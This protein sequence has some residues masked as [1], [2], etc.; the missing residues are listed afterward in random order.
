MTTR[1]LAVLA[2]ASA[3]LLAGSSP[4]A[5]YDTQTFAA[6]GIA[7]QKRERAI[8]QH[9]GSTPAHLRR[10]FGSM[11][12]T[13]RPYLDYLEHAR[14][15]ACQAAAGDQLF[16]MSVL[17][18]HNKLVGAYNAIL[19]RNGALALRYVREARVNYKAA[20]RVGSRIIERC[21]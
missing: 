20:D 9:L 14:P 15:N 21:W 3:V 10:D 18:F 12:R 1:I 17:R 4:A 19:H 11:I 8:A 16:Y 6:K 2:L 5:A 13:T 7:W